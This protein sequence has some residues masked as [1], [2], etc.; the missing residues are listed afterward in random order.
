MSHCKQ[1]RTPSRRRAGGAGF[2]LVEL[3]VVIGIIAI[4][5]SILMPALSRVQRQAH[6]VT[7]ASNLRQ[8]AQWGMLYAQDNHGVLPTSFIDGSGFSYSDT[9]TGPYSAA[10]STTSGGWGGTSS[11]FW[12]EKAFKPYGLYQ[13]DTGSTSIPGT[14]VPRGTVLRCPSLRQFVQKERNGRLGTNYALNQYLGGREAFVVS[15]VLR[16]APLPR[17]NM[18]SADTYWFS[19]AGTRISG[20]SDFDFYFGVMQLG[21]TSAPTAATTLTAWPWPWDYRN[22]PALPQLNGHPNYMANFVYG[23][24]HVASM[25]RKEYESLAGEQLKKFLGR[26]Y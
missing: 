10:W 19:D 2:T 18:L 3:L 8:I 11:T 14:A 6:F 15:S 20:L 12:T 23:D 4:L 17:S 9:G 24:G 26:F 1:E 21:T 22:C 25:T 5:I 16:R 7:C 13:L